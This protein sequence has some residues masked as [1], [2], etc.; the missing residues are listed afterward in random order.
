MK[1]VLIIVDVQNDFCAGGALAVNGADDIVAV[2]N[3]LIEDGGYD[4]VIATRDWHPENHC[5]FSAGQVGKAHCVQGTHGAELHPGL[6]RSGIHIF[7]EKG[8]NPLV[9]SNSAFRDNNHDQLTGLD[10]I[11]RDRVGGD[12]EIHVCGLTTSRCAKMTALDARELLP[13]ATVKF[14]EDASRAN[15]PESVI[16]AKLEMKAAGIDIIHSQVI[17]SPLCP[18]TMEPTIGKRF[19]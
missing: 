16:R 11:I 13:N 9:D 7:F 10:Q 17:L 1:K 14:I 2:I 3:R 15:R 19:P 12:A 5:S 8:Q 18:A 4:L 6:N